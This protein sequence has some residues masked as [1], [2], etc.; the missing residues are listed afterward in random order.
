[1][2]KKAT[3]SI[4]INLLKALLSKTTLIDSSNILENDKTVSWDGF[5]LLYNDPSFKKDG[6]L[7]KVST[8]VKTI[9]SESKTKNFT[10]S[11]NDLENY[12]KE[13]HIFYFYIKLNKSDNPTFYYLPL[14]RDVDNDNYKK[15][16][17]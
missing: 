9:H 16:H 5:F 4:G 8:Q 7:G 12:K 17:D 6:L 10:I 13:G 14:L 1:M 2:G 3:E 11:R 15:Q